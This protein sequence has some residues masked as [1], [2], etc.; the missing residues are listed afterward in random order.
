MHTEQYHHHQ[1][2]VFVFLSMEDLLANKRKDKR[3]ERKIEDFNFTFKKIQR[4]ICDTKGPLSIV[5]AK[6]I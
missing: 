4:P 2:Q 6:S 1:K 3:T 5:N